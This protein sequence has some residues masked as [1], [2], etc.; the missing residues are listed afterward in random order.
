MMP[1]DRIRSKLDKELRPLPLLNLSEDFAT[2]DI[3]KKE[4][5]RVRRRRPWCWF[6]VLKSLLLGCALR[7]VQQ[8]MSKSAC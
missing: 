3:T 5:A 8:V 6:I 1:E 4:R 7:L 2:S